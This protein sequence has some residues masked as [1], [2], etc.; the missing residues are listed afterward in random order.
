[1]AKRMKKILIIGV[2]LLTLA[3]CQQQVPNSAEGVGFNDYAQYE[4]ERARREASLQGTP[5][6][7]GTAI[8]LPTNNQGVTSPSL[9][10]I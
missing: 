8:V 10:H 6:P 4:L 9:I 7:S 1:M 3:G 5:L 2:S